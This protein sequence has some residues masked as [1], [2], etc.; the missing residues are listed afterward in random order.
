LLLGSA[1]FIFGLL[2]GPYQLTHFGF[3]FPISSKDG[4]FLSTLFFAIGALF[5]KR[6]PRVNAITA[7]AIAL[8]GFV[9]YCIEAYSL[10]GSQ[11]PT[12]HNFLIGSVPWS[13]GLFLFAFNGDCN[14]FDKITEKYGKYVI[15]IYACHMLFID[16]FGNLTKISNQY[17]WMFLYPVLVYSVSLLLT[18]CLYKTPFRIFVS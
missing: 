3:P 12:W 14:F 7:I 17:V 5:S 13:V 1:L 16:I 8:F 18:V 6:L 11:H 9:I 4:I 2:G 10:R 15:G